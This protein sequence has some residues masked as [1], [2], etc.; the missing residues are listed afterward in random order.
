MPP[1]VA[2]RLHVD[3]AGATLHHDARVHARTLE[4]RFVRGGFER[5]L[6]AA[7]D[8]FI[9]GDEQLCAAVLYAL[10]QSARREA[11][12]HDR[13]DRADTG[14][15]EHRHGQFGDHREVDRHPVAALDALLLEHVGEPAHDV[16]Q[17]LV[18]ERGGT[19]VIPLPDKRRLVS[20]PG[21]EMP[22]EAV[23]RDVEC[24]VREPLAVE[25]V[26]ISRA[27]SGERRHPRELAP[28]SIPPKAVRIFD[29]AA[30][31]LLIRRFPR[32]HRVLHERLRRWERTTLRRVMLDTLMRPAGHMM[33]LPVALYPYSPS[34]PPLVVYDRHTRC[35]EPCE[36]PDPKVR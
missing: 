8:P 7:A 24:A 32:H 22:V 35:E 10:S 14:A 3:V 20:P 25:L 36:Q 1:R 11:A 26:E 21:I 9:R 29:R 13:V 27:N 30:V 23:G 31:R 18:G 17:L 28:G 2:A 19:A 6:A 5:H 15:R 16:M 12:E 33:L 4:Q 34:T